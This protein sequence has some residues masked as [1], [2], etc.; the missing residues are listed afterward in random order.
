MPDTS[1]ES[2]M[3]DFKLLAAQAFVMLCVVSAYALACN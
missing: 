3:I 1:G 2:K